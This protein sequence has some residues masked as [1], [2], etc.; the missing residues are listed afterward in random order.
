MTARALT[1]THV[2][3]EGPWRLQ[4]WLPEAGLE[5]DVVRPY[6]GEPL[7]ALDGYAAL[8]V[9]GGPMSVHDTAEHPWLD[10]TQALLRDAVAAG[11]PTLAICLGAQLLATATGGLVLPAEGG[12]E[13]GYRLVAKRDDSASDL[14]FRA[15]P[16]TPPV[17][18]WHSDE[19]A[20]LPAGAVLLASSP[21]CPVQVFRVGERAW[22]LQFHPEATPE[23]VAR[24]IADD[25]ALLDELGLDTAL[26]QQRVDDAVDELTET[27][28]PFAHAFAALALG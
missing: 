1:I 19:V 6:A 18:Q 28:R 27:W 10:G 7:P 13:V 20:E 22:G 21:R 12:P 8:I 23:L 25:A 14:L 26:L 5:L 11:L 3:H 17:V 24:W 16:F 4:E 2:E 15:V 9:L